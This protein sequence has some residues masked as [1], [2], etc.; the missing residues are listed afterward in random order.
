MDLGSNTFLIIILAM[1][2]GRIAPISMLM[3]FIT[4]TGN[5]DALRYPDGRFLMG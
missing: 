5:G 4:G 1:Y 3:F 2:S